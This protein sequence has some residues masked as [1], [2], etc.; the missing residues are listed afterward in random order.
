MIF[1]GPLLICIAVSVIVGLQWKK[2]KAF[3]HQIDLQVVE[4]NIALMNG[5]TEP[6]KEGPSALKSSEDK[7]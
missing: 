6:L 5:A 4:K 2:N 1:L 3:Q 7:V